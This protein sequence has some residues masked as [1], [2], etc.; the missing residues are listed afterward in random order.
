MEHKKPVKIF[1]SYSR[2]DIAYKEELVEFLAPMRRQGLINDWHDKNII[3]GEKW[4]DELLEELATTDVVVFLISP[5]FLNSDY[6]DRVEIKNALK[7]QQEGTVSIV[8]ILVRPS[9][10]KDTEL[11]SFMALPS[12]AKSVSE[13]KSR[14]K[15]WLEITEGL[16]RV[17]L[18]IKRNK[19]LPSTFQQKENKTSTQFSNQTNISG[20][21]NIVIQG[22]SGSQINIASRKQT[23][24]SEATKLISKAK[25]EEAINII[26]DYTN[27]NGLTAWHN[28]IILQS[29]RLNSLE[30]MV[31]MGVLSHENY[32]ISLNKINAALLAIL[33]NMEQE[34]SQK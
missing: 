30:R 23:I 7:R 20:N 6:I 19:E 27:K 14:D 17:I 2:K 24:L 10:F 32:R 12:D 18:K 11:A 28:D 5:S 25:T 3:P 13:H 33:Y 21:G 1:I 8:P 4:E 31:R 15:A 16:K 9:F 34:I 22:V 29:S 26:L